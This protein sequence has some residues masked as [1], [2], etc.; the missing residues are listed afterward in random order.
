MERI[1]PPETYRFIEGKLHN[2]KLIEFEIEQ[3]ELSIKHPENKQS[4]PGAGYISDP[5]ANQAIKLANLPKYI[6]DCIKWLEL[7][8]KTEEFCRRRK[9]RIFDIWYGKERQTVTRAYTRNG[10]SKMRFKRNRDSAV[11]FLL[12]RAM[13]A[14]LCTLNEEQRKTLDEN[15]DE[16]AA[17]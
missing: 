14:G 12:F 4:V 1:I 5:T 15:T 17:N 3:W 11:S 7:I 9:N 10:L 13:A 8:D 6:G 2:R 16:N